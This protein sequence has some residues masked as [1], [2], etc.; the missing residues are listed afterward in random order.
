M[1]AV[2]ELFPPAEAPWRVPATLFVSLTGMGFG[3]WL[4]GALF[5]GFGF[6]AVAW[7]VG[8]AFNLVQ[9]GLLG[10]LISRRTR[11]LRAVAA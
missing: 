8:I 2:R 4:A 11:S 1:L 9:L 5:D 10:F 6:Y 7:M 3:S